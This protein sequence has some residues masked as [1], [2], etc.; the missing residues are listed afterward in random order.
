MKSTV[1]SWYSRLDPR[2]ASVVRSGITRKAN[3]MSDETPSSRRLYRL[4]PLMYPW[5]G[6]WSTCSSQHWMYY[7]CTNTVLHQSLG[8]LRKVWRW[9]D[10][11]GLLTHR[12]PLC[13]HAPSTC[14]ETLMQIGT[15][16]TSCRSLDATDYKQDFISGQNTPAALFM[17]LLLC[18][19]VD[20][21][22]Q[23]LLCWAE[24]FGSFSP[25]V[26]TAV[27]INA[28]RLESVWASNIL[29]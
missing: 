6:L 23:L 22:Q 9:S 7:L 14:R 24:T 16:G 28:A 25:Y 26:D 1:T 29:K 5:T 12:V 15:C 3:T 4:C 27:N 2:V 18:S 8:C 10:P 20:D 19:L 21:L 17:S 11:P 13:V